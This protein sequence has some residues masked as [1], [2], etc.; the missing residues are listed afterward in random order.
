MHVHEYWASFQPRKSSAKD[1]QLFRYLV[2]RTRD[3][4]HMY[5]RSYNINYYL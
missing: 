4:R 2:L 3:I 5:I 1:N